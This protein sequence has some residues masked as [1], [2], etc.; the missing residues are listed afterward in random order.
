MQSIYSEDKL[1]LV[2]VPTTT[3]AVALAA[4]MS[5]SIALYALSIAMFV[6][7]CSRYLLTRAFQHKEGQ[8]DA[9]NFDYQSWEIG[10]P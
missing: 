7:G 1:L 8:V 4:Y 2:G 5:E 9:E 10:T 3:L 6:V